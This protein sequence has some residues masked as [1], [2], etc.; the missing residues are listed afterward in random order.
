MKLRRITI[1]ERVF[2]LSLYYLMF[3]YVFPVG[4]RL[5]FDR[6][7]AGDHLSKLTM[8]DWFV[9]PFVIATFILVCAYLLKRTLNTFI[10]ERA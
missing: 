2:F 7:Q 8:M 6:I 5:M 4:A 10:E 1:G 3:M 9:I